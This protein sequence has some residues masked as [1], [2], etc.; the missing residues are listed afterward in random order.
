MANKCTWIQ[1]YSALVYLMVYQK[2]KVCI[3]LMYR[4]HNNMVYGEL[5]ILPFLVS[6][7]NVNDN[8]CPSPLRHWVW[9]VDQNMTNQGIYLCYNKFLH[10][11]VQQKHYPEHV[12]FFLSIFFTWIVFWSYLINGTI[13]AVLPFHIIFEFL[14]QT[15]IFCFGANVHFNLW[16]KSDWSRKLI[17]WYKL[18]YLALFNSIKSINHFF[19][20]PRWTYTSI[21]SDGV[22]LWHHWHTVQCRGISVLFSTTTNVFPYCT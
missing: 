17:I 3:A 6:D 9:N 7:K 21:N 20:M 22:T 4:K 12:T 15:Y 1:F 5:Y 16:I 13:L 2:S 19:A 11:W 10:I 14:R 8:A 18:I